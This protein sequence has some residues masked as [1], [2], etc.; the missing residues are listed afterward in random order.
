[1]EDKNSSLN[2][3]DRA[4]GLP[5]GRKVVKGLR[6]YLGFFVTIT[7]VHS[8]SGVLAPPSGCGEFEGW[9]QGW[10]GTA[11]RHTLANF[12]EPSGFGG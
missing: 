10:R 7:P 8:A 11:E 6:I 4:E 1:L 2:R 12:C 9:I 5:Q 3:C